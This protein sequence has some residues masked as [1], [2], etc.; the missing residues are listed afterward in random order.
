MLSA[1]NAASSGQQAKLPS[2]LSG[3]SKGPQALVAYSKAFYQGI[4]TAARLMQVLVLPFLKLSNALNQEAFSP[5][6]SNVAKGALE[7]TKALYE[8]WYPI[9][10]GTIDFKGVESGPPMLRPAKRTELLGAMFAAK[11]PEVKSHQNVVLMI[12][13]HKLTLT[14][15]ARRA[16]HTKTNHPQQVVVFSQTILDHFP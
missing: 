3:T 7:V 8:V 9:F 4:I 14:T 6:T 10:E 2:E 16:F 5:A 1:V 12:N 15:S 13:I 11:I